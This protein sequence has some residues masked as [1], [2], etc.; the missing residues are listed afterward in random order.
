[1]ITKWKIFNFKSIRQETELDF[2]PLTIFAGANSSG[3]STFIQSILLFAQTLSNKISSRSVV[4]N[5]TLASLGQFDDLKSYGSEADQIIIKCVCSPVADTDRQGSQRSQGIQGSL[6]GQ[7]L[8]QFREIS[9]EIAFDA[10]PTGGSPSSDLSQL[11][12]RLFSSNISSLAR[13]EFNLDQIAEISVHFSNKALSEVEGIKS[14]SEIDDQLRAS[15]AYDVTL[16]DNSISEIH[17]DFISAFPAGCIFKHFLPDRIILDLNVVRETAVA[18][19]NVLQDIRRRP[20]GSKKNILSNLVLTGGIKE[21]LLDV[22]NDFHEI[23]DIFNQL[24][25]KVNPFISDKYAVMLSQFQEEVRSLPIKSQINIQQKLRETNN[26]V[27]RIYN[28]LKKNS[29]EIDPHTI[30]QYKPPR[31]I[32][33]STI[34]LERFFTSYLKYLG[35]LRDAPKP[36]Y[37]L[38]PAADPNDVG[39]RGEYT[40]AVLELHKEK[41][42]KYIPSSHFSEP[43]VDRRIVTRTL[44]SAVIDWLQYLGVAK[45]VQTRDRGKLGHELKV[46]IEDVECAHDLTHVGVGVSQVLPILVSCLLAEADSTLVFEQPELHLHPKV[47]TLLGDFFL[48]MALC[49]KQTIVETHS[50]YLIDRL[51][52]R[53]AAATNENKLTDQVKMYFVKKQNANSEFTEVVVNDYGAIPDW[54]D[55]FF[56]QSQKQAEEIMRAAS[57][58]RKNNKAK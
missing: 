21:V 13:D 40:A 23:K 3:K 17:E 48:S 55:G 19:T 29:G 28:T 46:N 6:L 44:E 51:R 16:D 10:D 32:S 39:L 56:D 58:K 31:Q 2:G 43:I 45:S 20:I 33:D 50:E 52:F 42:I 11:Q 35:P 14:I 4:L 47:Q 38:A 37:P 7:R 41:K 8:N 18:I 24:S 30:I 22:L 36:I 5:G 54:P 15:I 1:M 53:I 34:F 57:I 27:D 26:L 12:P 25:E 49:N 9:C